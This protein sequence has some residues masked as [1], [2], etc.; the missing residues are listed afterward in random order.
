LKK[1]LIIDDEEFFCRALKKNL[2]L[3]TNFHVL[4]ANN[5]DDGIRLAQSQKPSIILLD[6]MM[7]KMDGTDVA[8]ALLADPATKH[9]PIIFVTAIINEDDIKDND[10]VVGGR[11]FI[12]KPVK[13]EDLIKKINA[14]LKD[15]DS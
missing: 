14:A 1:V 15:I 2:Q 10:G 7:P 4:T 6:I 3:K 13:T 12:A 9:T 11:T 5:G 8:E